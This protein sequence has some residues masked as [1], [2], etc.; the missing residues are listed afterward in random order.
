MPKI[1]PEV[2]FTG[3]PPFI[4]SPS[5]LIP[6]VNRI[7]TQILTINS[8]P[9]DG[10]YYPNNQMNTNNYQNNQMNTINGQY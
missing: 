9:V 7:N 2:V 6:Y 5:S 10:G 8:M 4:Y 1:A 3:M